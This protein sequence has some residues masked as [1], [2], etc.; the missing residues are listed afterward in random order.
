MKKNTEVLPQSYG[1]LENI[2]YHRCSISVI[3]EDT[4]KEDG[5]GVECQPTTLIYQLCGF[6]K[7][8]IFMIENS[9][10]FCVSKQIIS[11]CC[12]FIICKLKNEKQNKKITTSEKASLKTLM[13]QDSLHYSLIV[14]SLVYQT[15][16]QSSCFVSGTIL[17]DRSTAKKKDKIHTFIECRI[18]WGSQLRNLYGNNVF[19]NSDSY[20]KKIKEFLSWRS[21]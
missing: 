15:N 20:Y 10:I 9:S 19:S 17:S 14:P 8:C 2:V 21:G 6:P 4:Q 7:E 3:Q 12:I 16:T 1:Y 11:F 5:M 18:W 13:R